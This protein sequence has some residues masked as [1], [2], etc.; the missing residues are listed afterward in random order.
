MVPVAPP[1]FMTQMQQD[2]DEELGIVSDHAASEDEDDS[3]ERELKFQTFSGLVTY[4]CT[5]SPSNTTGLDLWLVLQAVQVN[6]LFNLTNQVWRYIVT[7]NLIGKINLTYKVR[8]YIVTS[9]LIGK[10]KQLVNF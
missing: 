2:E 9:N 6:K 5:S 1:T 3:P 8:C 10:I 7:S 4:C